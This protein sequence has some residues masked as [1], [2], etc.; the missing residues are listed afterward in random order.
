MKTVSQVQ[1]LGFNW[2]MYDPYIFCAHHKDH[3][4]KGNGEGGLV[5]GQ[6]A[7]RNIGNDFILRDGYRMYHG[8]T[9][10]GFPV[11]PHRGFETVTITLE[12]LVDHADS[13]GASGR[14]GE[15]DIQWM[16]AGKGIQ[17]AEMFPVVHSDSDNPLE[18]LQVWINLPKKN[19]FA[20]PYYKMLWHEDLPLVH[21]TNEQRKRA[22]LRIIAGDYGDHV[23][24]D[25]T[26]DSWASDPGN[27]VCIWIIHM[28]PGASFD[29]PA[30]VEGMS[31]TLYF[32]QGD[33]LDA[34]EVSIPNYHQARLSQDTI[35]LKNGN[36]VSN[37]LFLQGKP[38]AEPVAQYGPFV[39]N[40][41]AEIQQA[42]Q[43]YT[44][45]RFGGWPWDRTD[46]VHGTDPVRFAKHAD[47]TLI[48][49]G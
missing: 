19:K 4:P 10:P 28:E 40:T 24:L 35:H 22:T 23:A 41:R 33:S 20:D 3:Y 43:D 27:G 7:G 16:T 21:E 31:R 42:Y 15:G 9:V 12:G 48:K 8:E 30:S 38:I 2:E 36:S 49:R 26:P 32:Y 37:I 11:H 14:Y 29:I 34:N 45:T 47:G 1:P 5:P 17:H 6:L 39:M 46:P 44:T 18:L 13:L 25:P